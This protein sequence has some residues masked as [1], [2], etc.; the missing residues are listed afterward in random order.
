MFHADLIR[1]LAKYELRFA[2]VAYASHP[3]GKDGIIVAGEESDMPMDDGSMDAIATHA[4]D[5]RKILTEGR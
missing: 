3:G 5:I 2:V 4:M 1:L